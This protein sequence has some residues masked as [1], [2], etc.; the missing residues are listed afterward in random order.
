MSSAPPV[1][2]VTLCPNCGHSL[3]GKYQSYPSP[4][5]L[6]SSKGLPIDI[7]DQLA[8]QDRR[9]ALD[10]QTELSRVDCEIARVQSIL[11]QLSAERRQ[12]N[13]S[14]T[15]HRALMSPI[16]RLPSEMLSDIF[17]AIPRD[18]AVE[19]FGVSNSPILLTQICSRWR[20]I[21]IATP[22]LWRSIDFTVDEE[23]NV[24]PFTM[25]MWK[26]WLMRSGAC[27]LTIQV[28]FRPPK[29]PHFPY[30]PIVD[31]LT[32]QCHR[33]QD[34]YITTPFSLDRFS[35]VEGSLPILRTLTILSNASNSF[36]PQGIFEVVPKLSE[37]RLVSICLEVTPYR[38]PWEQLRLFFGGLLAIRDCLAILERCLNLTQCHFSCHERAVNDIHGLPLIRPKL[39]LLRIHFCHEAVCGYILDSLTCPG[40]NDLHLQSFPNNVLVWPQEQ[41]SSFLMRSSCTLRRLALHGISLK[42][43]SLI[44]CLEEL[45]SLTE[46]DIHEFDDPTPPA[47]WHLFDRMAYDSQSTA[48][49]QP[50]LLLPRLKVLSLSINFA[51]DGDVLLAMI[52]SRWDLMEEIITNTAV[53][54]VAKLKSVSLTFRHQVD[55]EQF[56]RARRW[57]DEGLNIQIVIEGKRWL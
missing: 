12:L 45:P 5:A 20:D 8:V 19:P 39:Q 27:P 23:L 41:L 42:H 30:R 11:E 57:R 18:P 1:T 25:E 24:E 50:G 10:M 37:V 2:Q 22:R 38:L 47:P 49:D 9:R 16:S 36:N 52:Q 29:V 46:L 21:A 33:W 48:G 43:P 32:S 15:H 55:C 51:P 14:M 35:A 7:T 40:L 53:Q 26:I 44:P 34:V 17:T 6:T 28:I 13:E 4:Q 54:N 3:I 56:T 31:M